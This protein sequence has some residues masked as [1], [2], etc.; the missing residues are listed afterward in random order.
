LTK[1]ISI[2]DAG[3]GITLFPYF[4]NSK[5]LDL[6]IYCCDRDLSLKT[7]F[8]EVN[9]SVDKQVNF[10]PC[11]LEELNF[12]HEF[13]DFIYCISVLEHTDNYVDIINGFFRVLKPGGKLIV[14]FDISL[15]GISGISPFISDDLI[16]SLETFFSADYAKPNDV[17]EQ[18][19]NPNIITSRYFKDLDLTL[20]PWR[21]SIFIRLA[22]TL[23]LR[24]N[25]I[26]YPPDTTF[27]CL[28]LT[29]PLT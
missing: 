17:Y 18:T 19:K 16:E 20:L 21:R 26:S 3:S 13:F 4:L 23:I 12:R 6:D 24:K 11:S 5:Y 1:N 8:L 9:K 7:V 29:K 14:T 22:K 10:S 28:T 2:L 27:Y 15:D 25:C